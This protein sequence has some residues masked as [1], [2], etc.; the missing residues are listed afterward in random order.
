MTLAVYEEDDGSFTIEWDE[1]DPVESVFNTWAEQDFIDAIIG[2]A[3]EVLGEEEVNS[4]LLDQTCQQ[5]QE[6]SPV[7]QSE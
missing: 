1:N 3:K 4:I 2:K 7:D 6:V 5:H